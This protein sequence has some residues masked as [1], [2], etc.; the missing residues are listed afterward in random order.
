MAIFLDQNG[1]I[2]AL[3]KMADSPVPFVKKLGIHSVELPHAKRNVAL[4]RL[5]KKVVMVRH[6]AIRVTD[7]VVPFIDMP[8]RVQKVFAVGIVF[9]YGFL[10]IAARSY[11]VDCASIF[12]SERAGHGATTVV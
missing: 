3:E 1:F 12:Y 5:N 4:W 2:S 7:P 9:E 11:M 10:L 6:Q 8:E